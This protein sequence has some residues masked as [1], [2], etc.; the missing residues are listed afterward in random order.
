[1]SVVR[2]IRQN[3]TAATVA[4]AILAILPSTGRAELYG[5]R[6]I[7][8]NN[9]GNVAI[10]E[11]QLFVDVSPVAGYLDR[12]LF[13]FSNQGLQPSAITDIYFE[14][15]TLL[16]TAQLIDRDQNNGDDGVD[17]SIGANPQYLPGARRT[18]RVTQ[19]FDSDSPVRPNGV[20]PGEQLGVIFDLQPGL[21]MT[22]MLH[23]L[24]L[25]LTSTPPP[26]GSLRIGIHV[27]GFANG[28][29]ESLVNGPRVP[30]LVPVPGAVLLGGIGLGVAAHRLRRGR[31]LA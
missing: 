31:M 4:L 1:M 21:A 29:S 17:F 7:T 14:D 26:L 22:D 8:N 23:A 11:A 16:S 24:D 10:G 12:V 5:F 28:G 6:C 27:Q 3:V 25:G 19:S 2:A 30:P 18:F 15:G 9:A 20:D 13:T